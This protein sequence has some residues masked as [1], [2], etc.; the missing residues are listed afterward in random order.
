MGSQRNYTAGHIQQHIW[1][2]GGVWV[3]GDKTIGC[4]E[5]RG[6]LSGSMDPT[7]QVS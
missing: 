2:S 7:G 6:S 4:L 1:R 5:D 3:G